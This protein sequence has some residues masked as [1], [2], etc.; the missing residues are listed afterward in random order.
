[1][2]ELSAASRSVTL[3]SP[4]GQ[5]RAMEV[6]ELLRYR[7]DDLG[8]VSHHGGPHARRM[9]VPTARRGPSISTARTCEVPVTQSLY[10]QPSDRTAYTRSGLADT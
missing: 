1:V 6:Q 9:E 7:L 8:L 10:A 3:A 4:S 5:P 2:P